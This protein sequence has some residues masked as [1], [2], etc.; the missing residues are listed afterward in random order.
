MAQADIEKYYTAISSFET[1]LANNNYDFKMYNFESPRVKDTIFNEQRDSCR[2]LGYK[3]LENNLKVKNTY[4][5]VFMEESMRDEEFIYS[6]IST[7]Q[8]IDH[9]KLKIKQAQSVLL[10]NFIKD[11]HIMTENEIIQ[12]ATEFFDVKYFEFETNADEDTE[13]FLEIME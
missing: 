1:M 10:G 9:F 7:N 5:K 12:F 3:T 8:D 6:I 2:K 13:D 4:T 11:I